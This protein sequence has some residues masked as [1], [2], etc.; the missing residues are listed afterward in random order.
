MTCI[1]EIVHSI[2]ALDLN[3]TTLLNDAEILYDHFCDELIKKYGI[4]DD[5]YDGNPTKRGKEWLDIHHIDETVLDDIAKRT[6][7]A[8]KENDFET[9]KS[10]KELN[11]KD[12]LLY[13]NKI[14]H[15]LLHYL[16]DCMRGK[17]IFSGGPNFLWDGSVALKYFFLKQKHL[18]QLQKREDFYND[19]SLIDLTKLYRKLIDWK[20]WQLNDIIPFWNTFKYCEPIDEIKLKNEILSI[21]TAKGTN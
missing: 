15:F 19:I 20:D 10:L 16:I 14:E 21:L 7:N 6:V 12:R 2:Q 13:A 5:D 17:D 11:K 8:I 4:V 9:L 3:S 1:K 18:V